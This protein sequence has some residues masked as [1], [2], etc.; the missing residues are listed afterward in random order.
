[1]SLTQFTVA[2]LFFSSH[3]LHVRIVQ[4]YE[5]VSAIIST[6]YFLDTSVRGDNAFAISIRVLM[7]FPGSCR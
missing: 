7:G 1:M 5:A 2:F 3:D 4:F 6:H